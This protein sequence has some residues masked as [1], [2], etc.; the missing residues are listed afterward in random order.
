[1]F[2]E[3]ARPTARPDVN[4]GQNPPMRSSHAATAEAQLLPDVAVQISDAVQTDR[5]HIADHVPPRVR[6]VQ[7]HVLVDVPVQG[8]GRGRVDR[9]IDNR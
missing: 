2:A 1:M 6:T 4:F 7:S 9:Y 5:R 3:A 8:R